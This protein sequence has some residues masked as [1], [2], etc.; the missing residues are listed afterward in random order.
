MNTLFTILFLLSLFL[1]LCTAPELF[2]SALLEGAGK[3]ASICLSLI[4]TYSVWMGLMG[5]WEDCGIAHTVSKWLQPL[6]KRLF[7]TKEEGALQAISMNISVNLLGLSGASTPYG[8]QAVSLLDKTENAEYASALLFVLNAT[9]LQLLPTSLLAVRVAMHSA[10]PYDILLPILLASLFSSVVG[11]FLTRA[12][13]KP[14]TPLCLSQENYQKD[15]QGK[16]KNKQDKCPGGF[17]PKQERENQ[18]VLNKSK[19]AGL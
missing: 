12:F 2:L 5:I 14:N 6:L 10:S 19:G 4:A 18:W 11:F 1:L 17:L 7:K 13:I 15:N 16:Q 3:G 8:I 9:S